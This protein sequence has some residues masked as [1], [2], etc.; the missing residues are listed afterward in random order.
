[1][2]GNMYF[3]PLYIHIQILVH[4]AVYFCSW[5]FHSSL[6]KNIYYDLFFLLI[7][8]FFFSTSVPFAL[9]LF[10]SL[11]LLLLCSS[12]AS[13][14]FFCLHAYVWFPLI[15]QPFR[16]SVHLVLS[17]VFAPCVPCTNSEQGDVER[18]ILGQSQLCK[19]LRAEGVIISADNLAN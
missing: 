2:N 4:T 12:P 1:M 8:P 16:L 18:G 11:S 3:C 10:T 7:F 17:T 15:P 19:Y 9:Y 13:C 6:E 14:M 5:V